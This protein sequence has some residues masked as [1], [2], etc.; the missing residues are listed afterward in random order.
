VNGV[1]GNGTGQPGGAGSQNV[2]GGSAGTTSDELIALPMVV[3]FNFF[4]SGAFGRVIDTGADGVEDD[5]ADGCDGDDR[6]EWDN[7]VTDQTE[8]ACPGRPDE[9]TLDPLLQL[10]RCNAFSFT[11][12]GL[13]SV[14]QSTWAGVLFQNTTCNW[15]ADPPSPVEAGASRVTFWAWSD[16]ASVGSSVV[17]QT[18]GVGTASTPHRDTFNRSLA[19]SLTP[20]PT[21]Y[22]IDLSNA[23][24]TGG[25]ISAFGWTA[26]RSDLTPLTFYVDGVIWE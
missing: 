17:F 13:D 1:G 19:V 14:D 10:S 4:P 26:E 20:T 12:E 24:Y 25:V 23:N 21:Q 18:G 11:P 6:G 22:D 16:A 8:T 2:S 15:G 7:V 3:D 5:F 9:V